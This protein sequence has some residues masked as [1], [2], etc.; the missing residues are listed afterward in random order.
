M[1]EPRPTT[2]TSTRASSEARAGSRARSRTP[3]SD[4]G[5]PTAAVQIPTPLRALADGAVEMR[6]RAGTVA[7]VLE[8]LLDRHPPLRRHL[9]TEAGRLR[10]HINVFVNEDDIRTLDGEATRVSPS[11]TVTIVPSIAGG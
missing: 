3:E 10:E 6:V 4:A 2:Q 11:D 1:T 8:A 9:R 7:A 5:A